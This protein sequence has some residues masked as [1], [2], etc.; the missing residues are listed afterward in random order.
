MAPTTVVSKVV[1]KVDPLGPPL[2]G[3]KAVPKVAKMAAEKV[4]Q[5]AL[6]KAGLRVV[7]REYPMVE[8]P[9]AVTAGMREN[10]MELK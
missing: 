1:V 4:D 8:E 9:V 2:A 6:K 5:K 7:E 3:E 10:S